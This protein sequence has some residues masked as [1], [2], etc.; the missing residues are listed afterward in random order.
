MVT[1]SFPLDT[2]APPMGLQRS[3]GVVGSCG[4][5]KAQVEHGDLRCAVCAWVVPHASGEIAEEAMKVFRCKGC[6]AAMAWS[7]EKK[8]VA[9]AFCGEATALEQVEDPVEQT[10]R[11]VPFAVDQNHARAALKS[12]LNNLGWFRP[13]D[14][15][16]ASTVD[17]IKAIWWPAWIF[18][19]RARVTW[20]A[21]SNAGAGRSAWAPHAGE[22]EIAFERILVGASRGLEDKEMTALA[23]AY[24]LSPSTSS[25]QRDDSILEETFDVQR[26][27]A[28]EKVARACEAIAAERVKNGHIPGST[29]RNIHVSLVLSELLTRRVALPA[30]ILAYRYGGKLYRVVVHGQDGKTVTGS[31]PRSLWKILGAIFGGLAVLT[32]I[33]VVIVLV[34]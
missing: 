23:N 29:F 28:R 25:P 16:T 1:S 8:A 21:D 2:S 27:A 5:C 30:W 17:E 6:G 3:H 26:S 20:T 10:E 12:W 9:C 32:V 31:A 19:A 24:D 22:T 4:R 7:A 34:R 15:A 11:W 14:L 18:D 13:S 33:A